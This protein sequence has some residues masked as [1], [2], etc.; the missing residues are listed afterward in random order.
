MT[1]TTVHK[2]FS[3]NNGSG[4][5]GE[6][7]TLTNKFLR[8]T[9]YMEKNPGRNDLCPCG[10]GKKYK[11]CCGANEAVSIT[12]LI[13]QDVVNIQNQLIE[14]TVLRHGDELEEDFLFEMEFYHFDLDH[15]DQ[16]NLQFLSFAHIQWST[17]FNMLEV[18]QTPL[19]SFLQQPV[20]QSF[21]P[22]LREIVHS[23]QNAVVIAGKLICENQNYI[24]I[25]DVLRNQD[26]RVKLIEEIMT[27]EDGS[28][29][30]GIIVPFGNEWI[31][32]KDCYMLNG[33]NYEAYER[34]LLT[35]YEEESYSNPDEY[36][37]DCFFELIVELPAANLE[38]GFGDFEWTN[39]NDQEVAELFEQEMKSDDE[40]EVHMSI[41]V[42]LWYLYCRVENKRIQKP[43]VYAAALH[44]LISKHLPMQMMYTQA[45][46]AEKYGV[47][48]TSISAKYKQLYLVLETHL[49]E[50]DQLLLEAFFDEDDF[51]EQDV[52]DGLRHFREEDVFQVNPNKP[53]LTVVSTKQHGEKGKKS[54]QIAGKVHQLDPNKH[55]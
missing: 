37:S 51:D 12:Y 35:K 53:K 29:A 16:M 9:D 47:S 24:L 7:Y 19:E 27:G 2:S 3:G 30:L 44:Y 33:E 26:F 17:L 1:K 36:L 20:I 4:M 50:L 13:E 32:F 21:R 38:M 54:K 45:E 11:R 55:K 49:N 8:R 43:E 28:F 23:W 10:S 15:S 14:Y 22:K 34:Y 31:F 48:V 52:V 42:M 46:I 25:H 39:P 5:M 40:D 6:T 18:E 41:G